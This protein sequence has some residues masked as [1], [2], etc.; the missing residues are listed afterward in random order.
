M[1]T[2]YSTVLTLVVG[3]AIGGV[4]VQGLHA[5]SAPLAYTV[6]ETDI[7]NLDA[8]QKEY[9]PLV[10]AS[11]KAAGGRIVA[12]GQNIVSLDGEAPKTRIAITQ[13]DSLD[14]VRAWRASAQYKEARKI[15]DNYHAKF[16]S[17]RV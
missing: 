13:F 3:A 2:R 6:T 8:Y 4:A 11:I 10:R 17:V 5:Q 16:R 14:K 9:I 12:S 15:G 1:Q 7:A